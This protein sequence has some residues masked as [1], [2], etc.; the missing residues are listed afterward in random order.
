[1]EILFWSFI[2]LFVIV[3][4]GLI[5]L[6]LVQSDKG[7]GL[8][9]AVGGGIAGAN[10][11]LGTQETANILTK[12]T[13]ICAVAY[14]VLCV[15]LSLVLTRLVAEPVDQS[16]LKNRAEKMEQYVPPANNSTTLPIEGGDTKDQNDTTQK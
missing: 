12:G 7:G 10:S 16:L 9:G 11:E 3:C 4:F 15:V 8:S 1:M 5:L 6:V 2:V 13:T 14:L